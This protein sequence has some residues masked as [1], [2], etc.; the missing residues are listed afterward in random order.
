MSR[1]LVSLVVLGFFWVSDGVVAKSPRDV[2]QVLKRPKFKGSAFLSSV[3]NYR[4]LS[5]DKYRE[6]LPLQIESI[7]LRAERDRLSAGRENGQLE[8]TG[9]YDLHQLLIGRKGKRIIL[10]IVDGL[11]GDT[12][13]GGFAAEKITSS[14]Q[15]ALTRQAPSDAMQGL[16]EQLEIAVD[17]QVRGIKES[18]YPGDY[19]ATMPIAEDAGAF[20]I[21][22]E[23]S[24]GKL[25]VTHIGNARL[26]L[27]RNGEVVWQ[28]QAHNHAYRMSSNPEIVINPIDEDKD[29]M[30]KAIELPINMGAPLSELIENNSVKLQHGDR[31]ILASDSVWAACNSADLL[32]WT[33]GRSNAEASRNARGGIAHR[34]D[35]LNEMQEEVYDEQFALIVYDY[36]VK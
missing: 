4:F 17:R 21:V 16:S 8:S 23:I 11:W 6:Q 31:I 27:I 28:T 7:A 22:A 2:L 26:L 1:V 20:A 15:D 5:S 10:G 33:Q 29:I 36:V 18:Q 32:Y 35:A 24:E 19:S 13:L 30:F 3:P 9:L 14:L 34:I 12:Y 25:H